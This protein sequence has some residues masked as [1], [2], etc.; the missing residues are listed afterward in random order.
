M[1]IKDLYNL[2]KILVLVGAFLGAAWRLGSRLEKMTAEAK[3]DAKLMLEKLAHMGTKLDNSV[4]LQEER[5]G[6]VTQRVERVEKDIEGAATAREEIWK[7]FND[8]R[9]R[10]AVLEERMKA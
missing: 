3:A 7:D 8:T 4:L 10:T 2:L 9:E 5:L 6:Q 1:D